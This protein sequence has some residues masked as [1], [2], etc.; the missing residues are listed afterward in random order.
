M[1]DS[2]ADAQ[3]AIDVWVV[4]YNTG[5]PHQGIGMVTQP[6]WRQAGV[7]T[8]GTDIVVGDGRVAAA[9]TVADAH[10]P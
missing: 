3:A 5:R 6:P 10:C 7:R 9:L 4:H 2:I 8:R 1:F